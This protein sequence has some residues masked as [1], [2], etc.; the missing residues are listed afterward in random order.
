M[1]QAIDACENGLMGYG[2]ASKEFHVPRSKLR[3][4]IKKKNIVRTGS[5]KGFVG[6]FQP[7]FSP[8]QEDELCRYILDM[9]E[10]LLGL[11]RDDIRSLAYQLAQKNGIANRFREENEKA[12]TDW[13]YGFMRRHPQLSLRTPEATSAARAR[14]FNRISVN[15]FYNLLEQLM[16]RNR[17]G[18]GQIYNVDETGITTVQG[19]SSRIVGRRGKKQVGCLTSA[20]RGVLVT[21]VICMNAM[22]NY[23]QSFRKM[24]A[25]FIGHKID[26]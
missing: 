9:E 12:G 7:V 3:D 16:H 6:G 18:P 4:R 26:Y 2:K 19:Q 8:N 11:S 25:L 22:G 23:I 17:Y 5:S 13:Y 15:A 24:K 14:G 20:E 21:A 1:Q 10:M